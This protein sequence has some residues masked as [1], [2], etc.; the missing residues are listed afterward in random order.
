MSKSLFFFI[1]LLAFALQAQDRKFPVSAN[2]NLVYFN[3]LGSGT[4]LMS[5]NTILAKIDNTYTADRNM[6]KAKEGIIF[7][8]TDANISFDANVVTGVKVL[9]SSSG[10]IK[11]FLTISNKDIVISAT[12]IVQRR[13]LLATS[14]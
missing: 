7:C 13:S 3:I 11:L 2:D 14:D 6:T 5:V 12:D 8:A 1:T 9:M 10:L 4:I